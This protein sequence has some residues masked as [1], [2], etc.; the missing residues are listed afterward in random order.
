MKVG[1]EKI[2]A[3]PCTLSLDMELLAKSRGA[4]PSYP[5]EQLMVKSRSLNPIWEDS[6]TMAVN[7]AL[8]CIDENDRDKIEL[9]IV[10][11]ESSLDFGKPISTYIQRYCQ[12]N[13]NCRNFEVKHACYGGSSALIMA[14]HWVL[15]GLNKGAKALVVTTDQSRVAFHKPWEYIL[16]AGAV[17]MIVSDT[18]NIL[19]LELEHN[20]YWTQEISDTFR[21][22]STTEV[23][24]SE[25]SLFS[26]FEAL[27]NAYE[28]FS[29]KV[30][31]INFDTY[32]KKHLYHV[33]FGGITFRAHRSLLKLSCPDKV[34]K[35]KEHFKLK[36]KPSLLYN[37]QMGGT[38]SSSIFIALI[39]LIDSC[40]KL[41]PGDR[42]SIFS[43]GSGACG[44]FYSAKIG[45]KA[46]ESIA[47][48]NYQQKLDSRRKISV[49][50][51]EE[52]E[53]N[54]EKNVDLINLKLDLS[55]NK[56]YSD[57]YK[58][59]NRLILESVNEY[60]RNYT[61]S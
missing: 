57:F 41:N 55:N 48:L 23:G 49:D 12:I 59:S 2:S 37:S 53:K 13:S 25:E 28:H 40:S 38:Y 21:P 31:N 20:G 45:S 56:I 58:G 54:R 6:I 16:G 35:A 24:Y 9:I 46:H 60:V 39:G 1:I 11:T 44:E 34:R 10:G 36:V 22:T 5:L 27:E 17:A 50:E 18:P 15:S 19:E 3:Y 14:A 43:Y 42:I 7:A 51:Y 52:I 29:S 32:F 26:Y 8:D 61:L 4:A 33:P 47:G 30:G